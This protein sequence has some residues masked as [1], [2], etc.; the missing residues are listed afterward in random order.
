MEPSTSTNR[1]D[2]RRRLSRRRL[3]A[4]SGLT[5]AALLAGCPNNDEPP[6]DEPPDDDAPDDVEDWED[7]DEFYFEGRV[8][9]WTGIEPDLIE[10]EEN[11][12][13]TLIDGQEYT[14]RWVNADGVLHNM[15]IWDDDG[16]IIDD[17]QSDDVEEEGEEA[18]IEG[19]VTSE[20]M[21]NYVCRYHSTT[22]IGDIEVHTG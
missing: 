5:G 10:G 8:A 4:A 15:E 9:A 20:E 1:P 3:L 11:P 16:E 18:T 2:P 14:F 22:Q 7:V 12:T 19:V 21:V 6:D 13:I 17:Y